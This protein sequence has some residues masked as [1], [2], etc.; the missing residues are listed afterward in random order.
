MA[1]L[2]LQ[3][4]RIIDFTVVIAGPSATMKLAD[5]GAEVI[6]VESTQE[7][8]NGGRAQSAKVKRE[9]VMQSPL[10]RR[11]YPNG[12]PGKRPWNRSAGFNAHARNKMC[13]TADLRK[14]E[15]ME[16]LKKL[17]AKSDVFIE[18]HATDY[19]DKKG[20][21]YEWLKSIKP[22]IIMIRMPGWGT[23]GPYAYW[24]T[25]GS[26]SE[27][28]AGRSYLSG[29][30]DGDGTHH[31]PWVFPADA[32]AG[33][34]GAL[35]ILTALYYRNR[36]GKGQLID[37]AMAENMLTFVGVPFLDYTM[38]GR[39]AKNPANRHVYAAPHGCYRAKGDDKW[40]NITVTTEEE[41]KG[42]C[43]ALGNPAWTQ[44]KKFADPALRWEN[45][46]ELDSYVQAWMLERDMNETFHF[47]QAHGVPCGPVMY[48][49][50]VFN[51]RHLKERGYF[52][53][54]YHP[55]AGTHLHPG[56]FFKYSETPLRIRRHAPRL[57]EDNE[58]VYKKVLGYSDAEYKELEAKGHIG[59]DYA[60]HV[61]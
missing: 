11:T 52:E 26:T 54:V 6:R 38:N 22:D 27:S 13:V 45:Q 18:N 34:A 58:Y 36:T 10:Q 7:I 39:I 53:E 17:V 9:L 51:D 57:G 32:S 15:G 41:W 30:Y 3:G 47:L 55:E 31:I 24:R 46:D 43:A 5:L 25:F 50:D 20:I 48:P 35:A 49:P 59:M 4:I 14:P 1:D 42:F 23:D 29:Y 19:M 60:P 8:G 12:D 28:G 37:A 44:D 56:M 33:A 21:T 61:P 40:I 2:P 16:F